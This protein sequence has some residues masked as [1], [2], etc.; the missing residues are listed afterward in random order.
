MVTPDVIKITFDSKRMLPAFAVCMY[1]AQA[2]RTRLLPSTIGATRPRMTL[3]TFYSLP[4][5]VPA[6]SEQAEIADT[7]GSVDAVRVA[8]EKRR[9]ALRDAK[10][11]LMSVLLTGEVRVKPDPEAAA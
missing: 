4:L 8:N 2:T 7:V 1:N 11:A 10:S 6:L 5:P 9:A 3:E